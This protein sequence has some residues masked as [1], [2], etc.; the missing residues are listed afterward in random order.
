MRIDQVFA[1]RDILAKVVHQFPWSADISE[2]MRMR[3]KLS[4]ADAQWV[5]D[6]EEIIAAYLKVLAV[7]AVIS[8]GA[9]QDSFTRFKGDRWSKYGF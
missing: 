2:I 5:P 3:H 4:D 7:H 1:P 9:G 6:P 8:F